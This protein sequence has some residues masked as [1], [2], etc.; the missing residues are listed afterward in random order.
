MQIY[1]KVNLPALLSNQWCLLRRIRRQA[2]QKTLYLSYAA[3]SPA[4]MVL[5]LEFHNW[6]EL[7]C[8]ARPL[9]LTLEELPQMLPRLQK[10][11]YCY[12]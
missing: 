4:G 10:F 9:Y 11:L 3:Q 8:L 7:S 12:H 2:Y 1:L 5:F 6:I